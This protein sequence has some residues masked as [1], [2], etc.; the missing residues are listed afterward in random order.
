MGAHASSCSYIT[1]VHQRKK[2]Q[3]KREKEGRCAATCRSAK[4]NLLPLAGPRARRLA[5]CRSN[6]DQRAGYRKKNNN[7][8]YYDKEI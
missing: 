4:I 7:V 5:E 8:R 2:I 3:G 1:R 6:Q